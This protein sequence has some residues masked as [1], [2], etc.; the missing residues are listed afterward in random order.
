MRFPTAPTLKK[1]GMTEDDFAALWERQNG[2][3]A[4]CGKD[5]MSGA[6]NIDHAHVRGWKKMEPEERRKYVRGITCWFD[7]RHTLMRGMTPARLRAAADYL[8]SWKG[9]A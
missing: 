7:N 2:L 6:I 3:C 8:E 5:L 9:A 4:V 1:Y